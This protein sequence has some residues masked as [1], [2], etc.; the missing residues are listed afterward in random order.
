MGLCVVHAKSEAEALCA[1]LDAAGIVDGCLTT[2]GDAF[3]HGARRV[4][5]HEDTKGEDV[6]LQMFTRD[7]FVTRSRGRTAGQGQGSAGMAKG[8]RGSFRLSK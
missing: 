4:Y 1:R 8:G 7:A 5:R 6:V 2:D 3:V